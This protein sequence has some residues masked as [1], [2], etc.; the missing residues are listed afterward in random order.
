VTGAYIVRAGYSVGDYVIYRCHD[1]YVLTTGSTN[2]TCLQSRV[3]ESEGPTCT[4]K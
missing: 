3:W 2:I 4:R 1:G